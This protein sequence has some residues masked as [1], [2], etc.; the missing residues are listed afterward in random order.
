MYYTEVVES[1]ENLTMIVAKECRNGT[2]FMIFLLVD[3]T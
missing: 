1:E 2:H 3:S